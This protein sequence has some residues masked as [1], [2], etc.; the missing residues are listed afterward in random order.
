MLRNYRNRHC[1]TDL[2]V[3]ASFPVG[4]IASVGK[5]EKRA[6]APG[7]TNWQK[8]HWVERYLEIRLNSP[9][10]EE[11]RKT[12]DAESNRKPPTEG[13]SSA[14]RYYPSPVSIDDQIIRVLWYGRHDVIKPSIDQA[15]DVLGRSVAVH[16]AIVIDYWQDG[17]D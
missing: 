11:L 10:P 16:A 14:K 9:L 7:K 6:C 17:T 13:F 8:T 1:P 2:P 15:L 12:L 3:A 4:E 5:H